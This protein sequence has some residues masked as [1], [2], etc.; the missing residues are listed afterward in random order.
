MSTGHLPA[1]ETVHELLDHSHERFRDV[2]RGSVSTVYPALSE[3]DPRLFGISIVGVDGQAF[4]AGDSQTEFTLMSCAKPFVF[5]LACQSYGVDEV[6]DRVGVNA[7]GLPFNSIAAVERDS[8]GRTNPM[9]NSGALATTGL[10]VRGDPGSD[11]ACLLE[12]LSS[13]AGRPL[14]LDQDT[15][16]SAS[17]SNQRNQA[18]ALVLG[19]RG[20]LSAAP[21]V[22]TDLYTRQSCVQ[23]T[24][25]DLATMGATLAD[26]GVNPVTGERVIEPDV[27]RA[28]LAMMTIAGLYETSGDWLLRVGLPA[29]SGISGALVTVSP[30]KGGLATYSP[31]LDEIGNSVRGQLVAADLAR[32]LGLDILASGVAERDPLR[33]T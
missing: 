3:A 33:G 17:G 10:L 18:I 13:F 12:G 9:V 11:W 25:Q 30:G 31:P 1:A 26:G 24:T 8:R 16:A 27:A 32:Q 14:R 19:T 22:V 5:A 6:C 15:Y 21:S 7:T 2:E 28:T 20:A 4:C 29:K 23:V